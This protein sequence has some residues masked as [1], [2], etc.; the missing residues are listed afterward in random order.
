MAL[1]GLQWTPEQ[2]EAWCGKGHKPVLDMA[3]A[4][5]LLASKIRAQGKSRP[6]K[7][8][9]VFKVAKKPSAVVHKRP[10]AKVS[11]VVRVV[12]PGEGSGAPKKRTA[13]TLKRVALA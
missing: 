6:R 10:A 1:R 5:R 4:R 12:L 2:W 13:F 7:C 11:E 8:K 3:L 9:V